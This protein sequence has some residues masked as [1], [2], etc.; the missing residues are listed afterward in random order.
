MLF[1]L[2]NGNDSYASLRTSQGYAHLGVGILYDEGGSDS[3]VSEA[4]SQGAAQFGIA[5][6][7]D[8]GEGDDTFRSFSKSQG[9]GYVG[10]MGLL[11]NGGGNDVYQ[12]NHG[13]PERGGIRLYYSPQLPNNGNSSFCQGA[14]FGRRDDSSLTFLSGGLGILRDVHGDDTYEASVFGQGTGYW[15]GTG[16]LSDGGGSDS[17]DAYWYIQGGAAHYAIGILTDDGEGDDS[18]N[19]LRSPRAMG[20]GAGH[21]FSVGVLIN[22]AGNDTYNFATLAA[23]ASNC[24]GVGLFVDNSG[25]DTYNA[26]SDHGSGMGNVSGECL[27]S[28]PTAISIGIMLDA[29]G[30]DTYNYP[31]S[32]FPLPE[33][34]QTWGHRRNGL[35]SEFGSGIDADGGETGIHPGSLP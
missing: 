24:N 3:Y 29:D 6:L 8:A 5:L 9:F 26:A 34:G 2:G 32:E 20:T 28:R 13:D 31:E 17:Y 27:D 22:E 35:E 25:D 15:Q 19:S 23:G 33:D 1:D 30:T 12:C 16:L 18:F 7:I 4:L 11:W 21:D 14:G 10:G